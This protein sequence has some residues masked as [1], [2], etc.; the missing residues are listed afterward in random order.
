MRANV[1]G[2]TGSVGVNTLDL[3]SRR[4]DIEIGVLTGAG[5]ID[6]LARQ[7][8]TFNARHAVTADPDRYQDL[9][10]A[11]SGTEVNVS[12]GPGAL[13]DAAGV[14][15]DWTMSAIV[16]FAGLAPTLEAAGQGGILAL[17]N[18]ESLV[19]AGALLQQTCAENGTTL[20]P[21]DSEHSAIHQALCGEDSRTLERVIL[22]ASGGPFRT[23]PVEKMAKATL[24]EA[25]AHPNWDM[26]Q[27]ISIDSATMFNKALEVIEAKVLFDLEPEQIE[28]VI[29]PQSIIHSMVGFTDGS[30]MAQLGPSD[31]RGPIGYAL[32][33]PARRSLP[34]ERLNFADIARLEFAPE[35]TSRFPA[36]RLARDVMN[37]GEMA[38]AAFNGAK[39][40][41]LDAFIDERI[42]FL[43][44]AALVEDVLETLNS[45]TSLARKA[46]SLAD[47]ETIDKLARERSAA[48]VARKGH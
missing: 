1:F 12:A 18:K 21:V 38:G 41:A 27:R 14:S 3:I 22:T 36:L 47:I 17:A 29:H 43:D 7:A 4:D 11:L 5:N 9:K 34:V 20:V 48:W 44:M 10:D 35:D 33:Y 45:D 42:G 15:A 31:M 28:V 26:G 39:E 13:V 23:W 40:A 24:A 25:Q 16:G 37:M 30:I 46:P 32:N 8:R 6:L 19:C 2:A